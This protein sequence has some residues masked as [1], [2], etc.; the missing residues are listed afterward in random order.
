MA[1]GVSGSGDAKISASRIAFSS[2]VPRLGRCSSSVSSSTTMCLRI[3]DWVRRILGT[4]TLVHA[5]RAEAA[6]LKHPDQL[7][8]NHLEQREKRDDD[9][10]S[11]VDVGEEIFES[12][13]LGLRQTG[14]QLV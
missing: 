10:A 1:L 8:A 2:A 4:R 3:A 14:Q 9:P 13:R 6:R 7:Q 11:I 5:N 12:A